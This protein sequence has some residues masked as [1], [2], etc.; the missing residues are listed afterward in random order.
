MLFVEVLSTCESDAAAAA[1]AAAT[2]PAAEQ[3]GEAGRAPAAAGAPDP[4]RRDSH[5]AAGPGASLLPCIG[6]S[7]ARVLNQIS[8]Y[9]HMSS[10]TCVTYARA[11]EMFV[12]VVA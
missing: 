2:A 1:A 7:S 12:K 4:E 9:V 3:P 8:A 5:A 10:Q 6:L 11:L